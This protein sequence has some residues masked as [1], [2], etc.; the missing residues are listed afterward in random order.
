MPNKLWYTDDNPPPV[1]KVDISNKKV[2]TYDWEWNDE[3]KSYQPVCTGER[4]P[5]ADIQA[6]KGETLKEIMARMDG[7]NVV[8]KLDCAVKRGI[9]LAPSD[10]N[11][12]KVIDLTKIPNNY[13]DAF[14]EME[15]GAALYKQIPQE[16]RDKY[17]DPIEAYQHY[18]DD[19]IAKDQDNKEAKETKENAAE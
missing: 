6:C 14:N 13:L 9:V 12:G 15:K 18:V 17:K 4:D 7:R 10:E 5:D 16:Y 1:E 11:A 19:L 8:E 2:K 3:K